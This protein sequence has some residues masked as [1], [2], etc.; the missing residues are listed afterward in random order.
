MLKV[1]PPMLTILAPS[2]NW[3]GW[4]S[5]PKKMMFINPNGYKTGANFWKLEQRNEMATV[6]WTIPWST[7]SL[8]LSIIAHIHRLQIKIKNMLYYFFS[9]YLPQFETNCKFCSHFSR[10]I[11]IITKFEYHLN[12]LK[13]NWNILKF[14]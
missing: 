12:K 10:K 7:T 5:H 8:H 1:S 14:V 9:W 4:D 11:I 13:T 3:A 6:F 2:T